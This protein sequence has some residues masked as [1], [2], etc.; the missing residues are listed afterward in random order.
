MI[1]TNMTVFGVSAATRL[2][3][4]HAAAPA[5]AGKYRVAAATEASVNRGST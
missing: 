3:K 2:P 1:T 5:A 4:A